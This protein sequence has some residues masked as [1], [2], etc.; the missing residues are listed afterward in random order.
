M[1]FA[2]S[3]E[4]DAQP[5]IDE[6]YQDH[7]IQ[8]LLKGNIEKEA[9]RQYLRA[10]ASY[11]REFAN[12][13]ALLIPK[14]PD[15]SSV[16]FL[17]D[18]IQFIVNGEVEAHEFMADY[19]G[20]NYNEIVQKKVWPPSGDHYIKHMYYNVYA[21]EN[22]AYAIAAMAP[23]PYVYAMIAKRAMKD[24]ELNKDS[25]LAK[26]FEFY[27]TEMDPL[28]EVLDDL[29]NQLIAHMS[30]A[31]KNEVRE[32]Y[33]QSTVHELNFFN[34]AYTSEKWQFGGERV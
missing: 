9:L 6:I 28:I 8:E 13:Y 25:I 5:I 16:R 30:E 29:M 3:L 12:I 21:H 34:M 19:I 17:V 20:E 7:F 24:P 1:N 33:L 31:E 18:Q 2:E 11:L 10:D 23:C 22:A 26:W 14:M 15:L 4:R 27:N 32:N